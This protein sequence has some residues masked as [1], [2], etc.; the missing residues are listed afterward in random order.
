MHTVLIKKS[1]NP[2]F[3]YSNMIGQQVPLLREESDVYI[4]REPSGY[5]NIVRK[6][7][8]ERIDGKSKSK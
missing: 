3:W 6:T 1:S 4:C 8:G 5:T 7:D 2:L